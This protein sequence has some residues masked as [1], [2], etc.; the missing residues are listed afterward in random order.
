[1]NNQFKQYEIFNEAA[2]T[3]SFSTASRNLFI[4]QSAVSQAI[5][6]LE[7]ELNT[8]LFIRKSKGV[9]LTNEG[10]ILYDYIK[11]ALQLITTAENRISNMQDLKEGKLTISAGDT[12]C[13]NY[14]A[15]YLEEFH[16]LYPKVKLK[17]I[18]RTTLETLELLKS[19][20]ADLG[21]INLPVKEDG[22]IVKECLK[23]HDI[24]VGS[25]QYQRTKP[26]TRVEIAQLSLILLEKNSNSRQF[27]E[28]QFNTSGILLQPEIEIGAHDLLLQL[29][30]IHLGV[31]CVVKEFSIPALK[32]KQLYELPLQEPLKERAI[33]YTYLK[34]LKPSAATTRFMQ[35]IDNYHPF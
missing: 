7:K 16:R 34:R 19:G 31:S 27:M 35:M 18:N 33:G 23:V 2:A 4:S 28:Q 10:A 25:S 17:I 5:R 9:E 8:K 26:Y 11:N 20:Q 32:K 3:L 24:F 15:P 12:L 14:L 6:S 21:F 13:A 29:A 30:Q 1:M 22:F